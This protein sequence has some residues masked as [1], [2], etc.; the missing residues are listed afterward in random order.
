M[1]FPVKS[2][3]ISWRSIA[4]SVFLSVIVGISGAGEL[5]DRMISLATSRVAAR[6][7]SGETVIVA[8]DD[9][10]LQAI[11]E[12]DFDISHHS[13]LVRAIDASPAKRLFIDFSYERRLK[14]RDF[15]QLAKAVRHMG[16][17]VVLAVP[18]SSTTGTTAVVD[19]WPDPAFGTRAQQACICWEYEFWQ[20]W[21]VPL[22]VS[23]N[24][25]LLPS[26]SAKLADRQPDRPKIFALD[27]SYD[28]DTIT[29]Y[30]AID[31]MTGKL[32]PALRQTLSARPRQAA[33][34]I[35]SPDRR[36]GTQAR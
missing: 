2:L 22:A 1:P 20:V 10:T 5:P 21:K 15:P 3:I 11:G 8:L 36:R 6:P 34:R 17:R 24:G 23:V 25:R 33:R 28:T 29:Q 35:Y 19:Y 7:V 14:D 13:R 16:D 32:D 26:F 31:V 30:S 4:L 27:L 18:G 9:K 12:R